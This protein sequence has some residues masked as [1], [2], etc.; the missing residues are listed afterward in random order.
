MQREQMVNRV[1]SYFP[2]RRLLSNPKRTENDMN[3]HKVK[4]HR[5]FDT[6]KQAT[7]NHGGQRICWNN[8]YALFIR[9]AT[10]ATENAH[11]VS[12]TCL[13]NIATHLTR[14]PMDRS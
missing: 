3:T 5:N 7:E 14:E 10:T 11:L 4:R 8:K 1:S 12:S 2:K 9:A 6:K 13:I